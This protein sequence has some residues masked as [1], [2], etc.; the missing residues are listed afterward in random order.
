MSL[1]KPTI[2]CEIPLLFTDPILFTRVLDSCNKAGIKYLT[3]NNPEHLRHEGHIWLNKLLKD[4]VAANFIVVLSRS[5]AKHI[6]PMDWFGWYPQLGICV[7]VFDS[8]NTDME[9]SFPYKQIN[10]RSQW[11]IEFSQMMR[12]PE[13]F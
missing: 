5:C 2:L 4:N 13:E 11:D 8:N 6:F 3:F 9:Y 10:S 1:S 12:T 7:M